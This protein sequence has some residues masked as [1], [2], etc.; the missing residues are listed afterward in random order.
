MELVA[1]TTIRRVLADAPIDGVRE[2]VGDSTS[3]LIELVVGTEEAIR[4]VA[5][6]AIDLEE[7]LA[8]ERRRSTLLGLL[9]AAQLANLQSRLGRPSTDGPW[10]GTDRRT[11][12]AFFGIPES[13]RARHLPATTAR[14]D[15]AY[16]LFDHQRLAARK[17]KELLD[18]PS[19]VGLL[20]LPTGVGKTRTA[21]SLVVDHLRENE[22]SVAVW[23]A[24]GNELLEQAAQEFTRA[25]GQLGNRPAYAVRCWGSM[26]FS[27]AAI[28]DGLV[29]LGLE[30]ATAALA[31]DGE[32]LTALGRHCRFVVFDEAHQAI[33]P[34]YRNVTDRLRVHPR[35]SLLGLSAT[36]GRSWA[37]IE[38][39]A[40][41][42]E[43][44]GKA[45]VT[46]EVAGYEDPIKALTDAGYL[47]RAT[48]RTVLV[49]PGLELSE[50]D[51]ST[52]ATSIDVPIE[53]VEQLGKSD[54]WNLAVVEAIRDLA[55][56]HNRLLVFASSV[57][58]C[59]RVCA[60]LRATGLRANYIVGTTAP[61]QR[62]RILSLFRDPYNQSP[63]VLVNYDVLTTGFDAPAASA[64]VVAR[65]TRSLVLYSQMVGRVLRG[66]RAGGTPDCEVV[67]V[68]DTD[69]AGFGDVS[70]AFKNWDD[71]WRN[72]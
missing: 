44:F 55:T 40:Q 47:A 20:H 14:I 69:L 61:S 41:L 38:E 18:G 72:T 48:F 62:E 67:T 52:L 16:G 37:D 31:S 68:I 30:K 50:E 59:R 24:S 21:M 6:E 7:I 10:S 57:E 60:V 56:R 23:L 11:A 19:R 64:A 34:T 1:G 36:P 65:P 29:V 63:H 27:A 45:K 8:D 9:S 70:E 3:R 4:A 26:D 17:T 39:D 22:P 43:Y 51:K 46:L 53:M 54:Q 12:L 28:D 42:S 71:V 2:L 33:A 58:H 5:A 49:D 25:W 32:A 15:P 66:P 35:T 13:A